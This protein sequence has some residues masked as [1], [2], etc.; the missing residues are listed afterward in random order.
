MTPGPQITPPTPEGFSMSLIR[1][2]DDDCPLCTK[3]YDTKV[4]FPVRLA[5]NHYCYLECIV[6]WVVIGGNNSCPL[7][8]E[9]LY[10]ND[11]DDYEEYA[12]GDV[13]EDFEDD[14]VQA[15]GP[16]MYFHFW[17]TWDLLRCEDPQDFVRFTRKL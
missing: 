2:K 16:F 7:G 17:N 13:H 5:G 9:P 1:P 11:D 4:N 15:D 10:R 6:Q 14:S 12:Y 3:P 8:R